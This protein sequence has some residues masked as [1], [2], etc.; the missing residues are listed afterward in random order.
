MNQPKEKTR[1]HSSKYYVECFHNINLSISIE[2][3]IVIHTIVC[4][5]KHL[6]G[7]RLN[8]FI[9]IV[10]LYG[11]TIWIGNTHN[12]NIRRFHTRS[13]IVCDINIPEHSI[14]EFFIVIF[15]FY[16]YDL[17]IKFVNV[18][19]KWWSLVQFKNFW[20][21]F[22]E[23]YILYK[24]KK[25]EWKKERKKTS[26][27]KIIIPKFKKTT[28]E[29]R[30]QNFMKNTGKTFTKVFHFANQPHSTSSHSICWIMLSKHFVLCW[31]N[32]IVEY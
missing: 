20:C 32:I 21:K 17:R 31:Y 5:N 3:L 25:C 2:Y 29:P 7:K 16:F 11:I 8:D 4:I 10:E 9:R 30:E 24:C 19:W 12:V 14:M 6:K 18:A 15:Y 27:T 13:K 22:F 23:I 26:K 28:W 1:M